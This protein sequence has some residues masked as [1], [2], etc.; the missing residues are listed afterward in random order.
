MSISQYSPICLRLKKVIWIHGNTT[1]VGEFGEDLAEVFGETF[2]FL[3]CVE[4]PFVALGTN[5]GV[6]SDFFFAFDDDD[7]FKNIRRTGRE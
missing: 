5:D 6:D 2:A 4:R 1:L 7:T 3:E